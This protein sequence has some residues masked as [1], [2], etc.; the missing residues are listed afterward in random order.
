MLL[1]VLGLLL[2]YERLRGIQRALKFR[3]VF[4]F[5]HLGRVRQIGLAAI[6]SIN[7]DTAAAVFMFIACTFTI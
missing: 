7:P 3:H 6:L 4:I 5:H 2:V 1:P